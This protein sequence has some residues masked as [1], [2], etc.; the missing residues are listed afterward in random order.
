MEEWGERNT[1]KSHGI[2]DVNDFVFG[3]VIGLIS[4]AFYYI[5]YIS[6]GRSPSNVEV[7]ESK[8]IISEWTPKISQTISIER[9]RLR[10]HR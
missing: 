9:H 5:I 1:L 3:Y 10:I 4:N 7:G 8:K 6:E 2:N